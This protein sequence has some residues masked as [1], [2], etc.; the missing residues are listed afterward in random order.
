MELNTFFFTIVSGLAATIAMTIVMYLYASLSQANTKVIHI[1]GSMLTG[2]GKIP[3]YDKNK[4]LTTG[5]LVHTFIGVLF[6]L[7]YFLLW[8]WGIFEITFFDSLIIGA[9]SGI[10][11]IVVW[12]TYFLVH[13][14]PAKVSLLHYFIALFISHIVFGLVAVHVFSLIVET[15]QFW[16]QL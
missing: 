7:A 16:F 9:L 5:A 6:S 14:N 3:E 12:K 13:Q 4:V 2:H 15:P 8:N 10:F 1:L 11:A